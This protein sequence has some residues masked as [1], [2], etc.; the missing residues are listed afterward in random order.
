MGRLRAEIANLDVEP[1]LSAM[2]GLK[3]AWPTPEEVEEADRQAGIA[4]GTHQQRNQAPDG[5]R[6]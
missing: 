1:M 6:P 2:D 5:Q 3:A 4:A